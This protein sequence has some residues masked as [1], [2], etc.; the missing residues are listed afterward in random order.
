MKGANIYPFALA[1][2]LVLGVA[3][4]LTRQDDSPAPSEEQTTPA[5]TP[6]FAGESPS[7]SEAP[8]GKTETSEAAPPEESAER[9]AGLTNFEDWAESPRPQDA[10]AEEEWLAQGIAL[11]KE[12]RELMAHLIVEDPEEAILSAIS[13]R[14]RAQLPAEVRS[15]LEEL[16]TDEGFYGVLATCNHAPGEEHLST[17]EISQEVVL[18]FGTFDAR[19]FKANIY[20]Q[21]ERR[22]TEENTSLN[23]VAVDGNLALY[24]Y[25]A[26]IFDDGEEFAPD[27][28]AVY[29]RG[30]EHL[31]ATLEEAKELQADFQKS[32]DGLF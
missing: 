17:C 9:S 7:P 20:G 19:A 21:R 1:F 26:I 2:V 11:A 8:E 24:E 29:Y 12:R 14:R 15:N 13:P 16:V 23:G 28:F 3:L 31:A 18:E 5:P 22:L 4:W 30:Q 6:E 32:P 10:Q 27:R 25:D